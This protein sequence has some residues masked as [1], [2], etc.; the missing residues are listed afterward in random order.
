LALLSPLLLVR[1]L[2]IAEYGRYRQFM[3]TAMFI[4]SLAGFAL[5]ANLN[6][7]IARSPDRQAVDI[8]NTCLLMLGVSIVSADSSVLVARD[9]IVPPEI[10]S[11]WLL[12]A[13]Y[14]FLF[15]N[16]EVLVSYW[17]AHGQSVAVMGY[18]VA[19]TVWRIATLLAAT[20]WL[21]DVQMI[22]VTIVCAEALKNLW[23]Y[24]W[25][26]RRGLLVFRW[27]SAAMR[28][29]VR[30]VAPLGAGS[31][32]YKLNDFG[33]VVVAN[34]MGPVPLALYTTA[35]YQVPLVNIVQ[36]A[37]AD[38]IF[39]DMVKRSK[40]DPVQGL[41]LWK[42]AQVL[43]FAIICPAWLLLTYWA[44]AVRSPAVHR[45]LCRRDA[46]LPGVP[47]AHGP[48]VLP[49]LDA[50]AQ[51]GRQRILR[52]RQSHSTADQRGSH[53]HA[54]ARIRSLGTHVRSSWSGRRGRRSTS[55]R[56][57]SSATSLPLSELCQWGKL[58]LAL[59]ASAGRARRHARRATVRSARC[60]RDPGIARR[61]RAG[62]R[63]CRAHHPARGIRLRDARHRATEGRVS[64]R[65]TLLIVS[66][67][68]A[69]SPLVGAK[70]FSFLVREFAR[71]GFQR[72]RHHQR[73][74]RFSAWPR[75]QLAAGV[76]ARFIASERRSRSRSRATDCSA[77]S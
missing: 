73:H 13:V 3:A 77:V 41:L 76:R 70:R 8:T 11:A 66:Y 10:A 35:A 44:E 15:L 39:P 1:M 36:G 22:F 26:R 16:L 4:T 68:F 47:A 75:G 25:L 29:Q 9:W 7:L 18:T 63:D 19:V 37:L 72:S 74:R 6:Y 45:R 69:P 53:H 51:R 12:L 32:L 71:L 65:P 42:R 61:L 17:L 64:S 58:G 30:L 40:R 67:H 33:K 28:E 56:A 34:Q 46:L 55:A 21:H 57:C 5:S 62:L 49:V 31:V 50:A 48:P 24:V 27:D 60:R 59:A 52:S 20:Y 23:I 2:D 14:V 43:I 54:D 38:V